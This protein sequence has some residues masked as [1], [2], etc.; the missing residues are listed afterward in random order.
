MVFKDSQLL[1]HAY[2]L[3][4]EAKKTKES[5]LADKHPKKDNHATKKQKT[6]VKMK[7]EGLTFM[8]LYRSLIEE[9][10]TEKD[11]ESCHLLIKKMGTGKFKG[12]KKDMDKIKKCKTVFKVTGREDKYA[13]LV[14]DPAVKVLKKV[15]PEL[16][17]KFKSETAC[18]NDIEKCKREKR[19]KRN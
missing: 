13:V 3:I 17:K 9:D 18:K 11:I 14:K 19:E 12:T 6:S 5:D 15:D 1:E 16:G 7:A 8:A 2:S 10:V 4:L